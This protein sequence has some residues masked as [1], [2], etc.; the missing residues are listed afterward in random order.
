MA[1]LI[2]TKP[3]PVL[4]GEAADE[5]TSIERPRGIAKR[6]GP[7]VF[8]QFLY[9]GA[10]VGTWSYFITYLQDYVRLPEKTAGHLLSLTLAAFLVGRFSTSYLM[11]F[12]EP[13]RLMLVYCFAN[14]V[15]VSCG[16]AL[17]NWTGVV[18]I[19]MT[20]F[21]MAPMF[22]TIFAMGIK[23]LGAATKTGGSLLVMSV[24][25]G[26]VCMDPCDGV[27]CDAKS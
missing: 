14:V 23:G 1:A 15:L 3:F 12:I 18:A 24:I 22:P 6:L 26:A 20:S 11:K 7:A 2:A 19:L 21:F 5:K 17:H 16:I 13:S 10:Q 8:A 27:D 4:T 9:V 25:G